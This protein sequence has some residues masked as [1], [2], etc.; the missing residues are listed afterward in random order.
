MMR[1]NVIVVMIV[2]LL[3]VLL[4]SCGNTADKKNSHVKKPPKENVPFTNQEINDAR[5]VV[6][7]YFKATNEND[8]E[9]Y[10]QC[11]VRTKKADKGKDIYAGA[12][13]ELK[14]IRLNSNPD[15]RENVSLYN[16]NGKELVSPE[17]VIVFEVDFDLSFESKEAELIS[18]MP[19]GAVENYLFILVRDTQK[20]S[21]MI[22][23]WGY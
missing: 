18:S 23:E 3:L 9:S 10:N 17:N 21:W 4:S 1:K 2:G 13:C 7:N 5:E 14:E 12:N 15:M 6:L 8:I 11:V 22:N 20:G 16:T 19:P